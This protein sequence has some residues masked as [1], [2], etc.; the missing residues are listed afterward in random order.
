LAACALRA[1]TK[2]G[3]RFREK[4]ASGDLASGFSDLE[5]AWL[6]TA[7]AFAPDDLPHDL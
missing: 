4:N 7:L 2:K 5:M 6:F 1:T 3:Q